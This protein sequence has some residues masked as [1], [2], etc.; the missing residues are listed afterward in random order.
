MPNLKAHL[1]VCTSC[2]FKKADGTTSEPSEA[3]SFR[4]VIKEKVKET[5][6]KSIARVTGVRCL[7]ECEHGIAT[8]LYP[9]AE[10]NTQLRPD[11]ALLMA[12]KVLKLA[13]V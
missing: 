4:K 2:T 1:F 11:D 3:E 8:V 7:G 12:E 6:D 13:K 10:W 9:V 5:C